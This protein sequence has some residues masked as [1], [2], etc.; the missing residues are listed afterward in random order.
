MNIH[1]TFQAFVVGAL[2]LR[3]RFDLYVLLKIKS[4]L[5][6]DLGIIKGNMNF[7]RYHN[8]VCSIQSDSLKTKGR[9]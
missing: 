8:F 6:E 1:F 4:L 3:A 7:M 9:E 5:L 2:K